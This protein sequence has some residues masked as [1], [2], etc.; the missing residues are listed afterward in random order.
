MPIA[1]LD[2]PS[3]ANLDQKTTL[4]KSLYE[5]LHEAYPFPDDHRVFLREWPLGNVS[6]NGCIG[7]EPSRPVMLVHAP[8]GVNLDAKRRMLKM[9]HAAVAAAFN[10]PDFMIFIHEHPLDLVAHDGNLLADDATR[11]EAQNGV[12][13]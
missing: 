4:M 12:Y 10:L 13:G 9:L 2:V 3:G 8:Q 5:A 1:Y 6:Q 11:V 7:M